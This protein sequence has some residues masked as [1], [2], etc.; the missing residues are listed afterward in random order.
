[1]DG[2]VATEIRWVYFVS[3]VLVRPYRAAA[4][5]HRT[6]MSCHVCFKLSNFSNIQTA[7]SFGM[8]DEKYLLI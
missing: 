4:R 6:C 1:M 8:M 5:S 7:V 3:A 2:V